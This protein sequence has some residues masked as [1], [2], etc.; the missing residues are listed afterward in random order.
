MRYIKKLL[1]SNNNYFSWNQKII[2]GLEMIRYRIT[3]IVKEAFGCEWQNAQ[4]LESENPISRKE[5]ARQLNIDIS[6]IINVEVV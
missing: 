1:T 4:I 5:I 3:H 6:S 2:G